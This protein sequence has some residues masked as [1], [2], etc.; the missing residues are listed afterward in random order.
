MNAKD[1][2]GICSDCHE[3]TTVHEACCSAPVW[4]CGGSYDPCDYCEICGEDIVESCQCEQVI[5]NDVLSKDR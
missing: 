4:I 2:H 5:S 3:H 1:L